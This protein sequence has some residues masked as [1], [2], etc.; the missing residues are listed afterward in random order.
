[1]TDE[2]KPRRDKKRDAIT[3]N[4][5]RTSLYPMNPGL[6]MAPVLRN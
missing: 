3:F 1:V 5:R 4:W 6:S 2:D